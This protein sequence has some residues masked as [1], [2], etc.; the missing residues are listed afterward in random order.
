MEAGRSPFRIGLPTAASLLVNALMIA[1]LIDLGVGRQQRRVEAPSL[2]V[3][4]LA[5]L[6][7][8]KDGEEGAK[9]ETRSQP[10][11]PPELSA[12]IPAAPPP[13]LSLAAAPPSLPQPSEAAPAAVA[14]PAPAKAAEA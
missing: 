6:K 14:P 13:V 9:A 12:P 8:A 3:M 2:K 7:G 11:P 1:A 5:L 4:S 10:A